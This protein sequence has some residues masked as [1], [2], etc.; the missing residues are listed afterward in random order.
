MTKKIQKEVSENIDLSKDYVVALSGGVD[1]AVLA[2]IVSQ[3]TKKVRSV[4]VRH[5][6]E[7]SQ[8]LE[9]AAQSIAK[10]LK[11]NHKILNS[12]LAL[13]SS[14]T[15]MREVRY[16][17]LFNDLKNGEVLLTGHTLSDKVETFFMNLI[18][19]T[20]LHGLKSIPQS[21]KNVERPLINI[22]KKEIMK[23]AKENEIDYLDD[24]TNFE[25]K[26]LRNWIRNELIP[27]VDERLPGN[28]EEKISLLINEI[29]SIFDDNTLNF[30]YIKLANGYIE[31]PVILVQDINIK[32]NM[33]FSLISKIIGIPSFQK[34]D[35]TKIESAIDSGSKIQLNKD[36]S[37]TSSNS[38]LIFINKQ[39]WL[40][41]YKEQN[42]EVGYFKFSIEKEYRHNNNWT[43]YL[44]N[45][46]ENLK[47][48]PLE[49]GDKILINDKEVKAS[50]VLRGYG[51]RNLLKEVW[52]IV[53]LNEQILW[54]P[55]IRKS[56]LV[57]KY[58]KNKD[59]NILVASVEKSS[60]GDS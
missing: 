49:D 38:L 44:P 25:N 35:I 13:G 3:N 27:E 51:V 60:V 17:L 19:G 9:K 56:D 37:C 54:I 4:F 24:V 20:R 23:F 36:W 48:R 21:V 15:N 59:S 43:I 7:H 26:I 32:R 52:P 12:N 58:E 57:K 30:K 18:R 41:E 33:Y 47:I 8:E 6:Q 46:Y 1:S 34:K 14:E 31:I 11:I 29:E 45:D 39:L 42:R 53:S 40:N 16:N 22:S 10:K 2:K 55:G 5:N 28:L 50:E